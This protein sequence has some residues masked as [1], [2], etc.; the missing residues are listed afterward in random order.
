MA[1]ALSAMSA[2]T[3]NSPAD[4]SATAMGLL[5]TK[6]SAP[7]GAGISGRVLDSTMPMQFCAAIKRA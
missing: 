3:A 4:G 7:P 2:S 1:V 5:P 6:G